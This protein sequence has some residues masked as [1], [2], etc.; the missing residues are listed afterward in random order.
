MSWRWDRGRLEYFQFD[1]IRAIA[2]V[3][4][5][6]DGVSLNLPL[7]PLR[8]PLMEATGR[9]FSPSSYTVWRN[10]G[11]V[12]GCQLLAAK[13]GTRLVCTQVCQQLSKDTGPL[14]T[15]DDYLAHITRTFYHPSPVFESYNNTSPQIFPFCAIIK[16]VIAKSIS[17][18]PGFV[19]IDDIF[20]EL[21]ANKLTGKEPL[22]AYVGLPK[23]SI[24]PSEDEKR[25]IREL[26]I[27]MSQYSFLK[28]Q[29]PKLF[30][31]VS[32]G[33]QEFYGELEKLATPVVRSRD[34]DKRKELLFLGQLPESPGVL[35]PEM[36]DRIYSEDVE[37]IEGRKVRV[38]HL[39]TERSRKLREMFFANRKPP[40]D[41]DMCALRLKLR[42][43]WTDN[44]L[45]VH[46][47]LPLSSPL[48]FEGGKTSIKDLVE[49]CPSCHRAIHDFYR[50]WLRGKSQ[51]DFLS[52]DEARAIYKQAK[53]EVV[54]S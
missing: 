25:E 35:V 52:Y 22:S 50:R 46:H 36:K 40:Y 27:F 8:M 3:L 13:V 34:L 1:T 24:S 21:I 10:Y 29:N 42:Y 53:G 17:N 32:S 47:L 39:R 28:W 14:T 48:K 45:E 30:L 7:D 2:K 5:S 18:G 23:R 20:S 33:S 38:T 49:L 26:V 54:L 12:F 9:P 37:F 41:C 31:D 11:R 43:P 19:T 44:L 15:V 4:V 6:L 51:D 16:L